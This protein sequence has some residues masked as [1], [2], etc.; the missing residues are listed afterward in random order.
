MCMS[1]CV[2]INTLNVSGNDL[3]CQIPISFTQAS[4]G[5]TIEVMT[6]DDIRVKVA[7][8]PG[9]QNGKVLRLRGKG[10]PLLRSSS[11]Q[12]GDQYIKLVVETPRK[13]SREA[14]KLMGQ[15][16]QAIGE[17]ERPE[18]VPFTE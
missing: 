7:V 10:V 5:A 3:Y 18:P 16:A 11:N 15:L 13:L 12:R 2:H 4:L 14:K 1:M 17:N 6:I 8:P 9:T